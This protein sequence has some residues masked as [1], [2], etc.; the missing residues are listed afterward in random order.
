MISDR[1]AHPRSEAGDRAV[2]CIKTTSH[3]LAGRGFTIRAGC[4]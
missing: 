2:D 4:L 3:S 1:N